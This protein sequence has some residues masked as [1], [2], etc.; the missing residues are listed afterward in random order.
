MTGCKLSFANDWEGLSSGLNLPPSFNQN[1][2]SDKI[3]DLDRIDMIKFFDLMNEALDKVSSDEFKVLYFMAN[4]PKMK[5]EGRTKLYRDEIADRLGWLN[6]DRPE[7]SR[8]KVTNATNALVEKGFLVKDVIYNKETQK[9]ET[10]YTLPGQKSDKKLTSLVQKSDKKLTSWIQK[11][12]PTK[13]DQKQQ[14]EE[15]AAKAAKEAKELEAAETDDSLEM[16]GVYIN[17][18]GPMYSDSDDDYLPF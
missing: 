18:N 12:I 17:P 7:Y 16:I 3:I 1:R 5:K 8:K 13:K 14:K 2:L 9:R 6:E 15:K 11:N 10:F 4:S